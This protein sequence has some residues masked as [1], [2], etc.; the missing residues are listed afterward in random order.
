MFV[1]ERASQTFPVVFLTAKFHLCFREKSFNTDPCC[2]CM[3]VSTHALG[4]W[5]GEAYEGIL[6]HCLLF[7]LSI[8]VR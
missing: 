2:G 6:I 4:L 8:Q 5:K 1:N 7:L 3:A